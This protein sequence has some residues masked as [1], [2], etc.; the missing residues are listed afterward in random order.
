[1]KP[2]EAQSYEA[3][4]DEIWTSAKLQFGLDELARRQWYEQTFCLSALG[5]SLAALRKW[6]LAGLEAIEYALILRHSW[7]PDQIRQM[8][9]RD[10]WL[11]LHEELAGLVMADDAKQAWRDR[12]VTELDAK[13]SPE[14]VWRAYPRGF[15]VP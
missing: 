4:A 13:D 15:P 8:S 1:M 9:P 6:D 12:E 2:R 10:K 11:S 14:D 7:F 3:L 5:D